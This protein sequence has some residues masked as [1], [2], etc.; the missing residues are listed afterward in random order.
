MRVRQ[1]LTGAWRGFLIARSFGVSRWRSALAALRF[2]L[3]GHTRFGS[4][5]ARYWR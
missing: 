5:P 3:V 4:I 2:V 1:R